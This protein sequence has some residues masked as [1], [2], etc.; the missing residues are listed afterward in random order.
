MVAIHV[1]RAIR[2]IENARGNAGAVVQALGG[3]AG[4]DKVRSAARRGMVIEARHCIQHCATDTPTILNT[5]EFDGRH[6]MAYFAV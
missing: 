2:L 3:N 1:R 4:A 5:G 6:F